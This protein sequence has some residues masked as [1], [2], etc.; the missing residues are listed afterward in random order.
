MASSE[1][2]DSDVIEGYDPAN[3]QWIMVRK[4]RNKKH[5]RYEGKADEIPKLGPPEIP[6]RG[7]CNGNEKAKCGKPV[8]G[9]KIDSISCDVCTRWYHPSCQGIAGNMCELITEAKLVWLCSECKK[10]LPRF[11]ELIENKSAEVKHDD[12]SL[13]RI[14]E[15]LDDIRKVISHQGSVLRETTQLQAEAKKTYAEIAK[16]SGQF[17]GGISRDMLK[18]CIEEVKVQTSEQDRRKCNLVISNLPE[19][20]I[21]EDMS[22]FSDILKKELNLSLKPSKAYRAGKRLEGKPRLLIVTMEDEGKKWEVLKRGKLL[23]ESA[24]EVLKSVYI[25]LDL[26]FEERQE[27]KKL[28]EELKRRRENG[29]NVKI[30]RGKCVVIDEVKRDRARNAPHTK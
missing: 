25:N 1:E 11:R 30:I 29:E 2:D 28:R 24:D 17:K 3:E 15:K 8:W 10:E 16:A 22:F 5:K 6:R 26:T 9:T 19:G 23:R 27:N 18:E 14:E 12:G 4:G 7:T 21:S 20:G 13:A